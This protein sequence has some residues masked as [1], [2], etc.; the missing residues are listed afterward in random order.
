MSELIDA[1]NKSE[2][3][4]TPLLATSSAVALT[5]YILSTGLAVAD[6]A[7]RSTVWIELGGQAEATQGMS[8]PFTAPFMSLDPQP[9]VYRGISFT[10]SQ[11]PARFAVGAEGKLSFQPE[12]SD[13]TFAAA[14]RYGRSNAKRHTHK[15]S[16]APGIPFDGSFS[17]TYAGYVYHYT[18]VYTKTFP[19]SRLADTQ[20]QYHEQHVI[21]DFT[22]GK[23]VGLGLLGRQGSSEIN[24]GVRF[25]SF[26]QSST[27]YITAR[28]EIN[29]VHKFLH[30][31][32]GGDRP[33]LRSS[34]HQYTMAASAARSFRGV[35]PSL[36]W[37]A[38]AALAG[39]SQDAQLNLDWG[40]N[41]AILF[42]RQKAMVDH[43][44]QAHHHLPTKYLTN[45]YPVTYHRHPA[46]SDRSRSVVMPNL[47]GFAG[48][49]MNYPNAKVSFGYRADFFFGAMDTGIDARHSSN[50]GFHG[51]FATIS[52]GLGG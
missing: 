9:D 49:S 36:S 8:S 16:Q 5:A 15:Q 3:I 22:A 7:D 46:P 30:T 31:Y 19:K 1:R 40:V 50:V 41:A 13:W 37:N 10:G 11:K 38:S 12:G 14:I 52:I 17:Y 25:A 6:D 27:A 32:F 21:L 28:P 44:T 18:H 2:A 35:G 23:D 42:G 43:S 26:T 45:V 51:P 34:F 4:R 20:T 47:G 33:L 39:N 24:A 48:L 29:A